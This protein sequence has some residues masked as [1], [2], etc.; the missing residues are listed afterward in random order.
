[1]EHEL[2]ILPEYFNEVRKG[3]KTFEIRKN[4][5]D[6]K[7]GDSLKL[8]EFDGD[9]YTGEEVSR[10]ITYILKDCEQ[11]GLKDGFVILAME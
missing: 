3:S 10:T 5:R 1:M 8:L 2:K 6:Y 7:V 4:N 9:K 11:Y